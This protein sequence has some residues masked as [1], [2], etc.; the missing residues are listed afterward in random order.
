MDVTGQD[1]TRNLPLELSGTGQSRQF[2]E[3]SQNKFRL[4][5]CWLSSHQKRK[6]QDEE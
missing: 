4:S 2:K 6:S 5:T 3:W 1:L